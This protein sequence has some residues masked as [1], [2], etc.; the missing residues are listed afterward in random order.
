MNIIQFAGFSQ[1][2]VDAM[3]PVLVETLGLGHQVYSACPVAAVL[4]YDEQG[5]RQGSGKMIII[6]GFDAIRAKLSL[7]NDLSQKFGVP[8]T[9]NMAEVKLA[10]GGDLF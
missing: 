6:P 3:M 2:E 9:C 5:K 10:V 4:L 1:N 7:L 8:V